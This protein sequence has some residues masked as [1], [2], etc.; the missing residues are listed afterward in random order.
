MSS[1]SGVYTV[2]IITD[3][4]PLVVWFSNTTLEQATFNGEFG[5]AY[6]FVVT[7]TDNVSN[8]AQAVASTYAVQATK[9]YYLGSSRVAMRQSAAS[10]D[11]EVSYL[12]TD[13]L[14][15]VSAVTDDNGDEIARTLNL[16]FGEVRWQSG[17]SPTD[18][19][20]TG[21]KLDAST[22]LHCYGARYYSSAVGRFTSSDT[23]VPGVSPQ[24]LNHYS[25]A[26]N[27]P[28]VYSDPSGH[29]PVSSGTSDP[30]GGGGF[31][32]PQADG[33]WQVIN[34]M[35]QDYSNI[36]VDD[37]V[38][39]S[40][41]TSGDGS[42]QLNLYLMDGSTMSVQLSS[43]FMSNAQGW[44]ISALQSGCSSED[45]AEYALS[46]DDYP[47]A[48]REA[49]GDLLLRIL[50][51]IRLVE[52]VNSY[53]GFAAETVEEFFSNFDVCINSFSP[54]TLVMSRNGLLPISE[55]KIGD[56]VLAYDQT[57]GTIGYFPIEAISIHEDLVVGYL[58][59]NGEK[60][61]TTPGH[62]F[63]LASDEWIAAGSLQIGTFVRKAS[64]GVGELQKAT[65][66]FDP[67]VMYNLTVAQAHT[68]FVGEQQW[69]VHNGHC[70]VS[71][72]SE[73]W[74]QK[75]AHI[76]V[77]VGRAVVELSVHPTHE[78]RIKFSPF[79]SSTPT[80]LV[81]AAV[82]LAMEEIRD[83]SRFQRA[84]YNTVDRAIKYL[85]ASSNTMWTGRAAEMFFLKIVLGRMFGIDD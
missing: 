9:Y 82:K 44:D 72:L 24:A 7:T 34:S 25:Y 31:F 83:D 73:D 4:E 74:A 46:V 52:Q 54:D 48:W 36:S 64:W 8:T 27:N 18:Y 16:P 55:L 57:L 5:H 32:D 69:L 3:T 84:L 53:N 50:E 17:A 30:C 33:Y 13:H 80:R 23:V 39:T 58:V 37:I 63:Y 60:I 2:S 21:Q 1:P 28:L 59:I 65:F 81:E 10:G 26:Y 12:H 66:V 47:N 40:V 67:Q 75:G 56:Y 68:F 62:L 6:T 15:T 79:F 78:G 49:L 14:G 45:G 19:S 61:Q 70:T 42:S 85:G 22:G 71:P 11:G 29:A 41:N 76:K 35:N 20:F 51:L 77:S 43:N 38:G